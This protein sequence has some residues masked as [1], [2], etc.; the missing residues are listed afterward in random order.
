MW[1]TQEKKKA[2]IEERKP[3]LTDIRKGEML[4]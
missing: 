3:S 2:K 4:T 1:V